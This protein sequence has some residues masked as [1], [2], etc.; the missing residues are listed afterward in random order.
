MRKDLWLRKDRGLRNG[1]WLRNGL[2][3][4]SGLQLRKQRVLRGHPAGHRGRRAL[5]RPDPRR[6]QA[7]HQHGEPASGQHHPGRTA[8][9]HEL[10]LYRPVQVRV[11]QR[12]AHRHAERLPQLTAGGSNAG[13][14]AAWLDGMAETA[15]V[16]I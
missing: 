3:L 12:A 6:G 1:P 2:Q 4:R 7:E 15:A 5:R 10:R 11:Q 14:Q 9:G 16:L 13:G 8:R